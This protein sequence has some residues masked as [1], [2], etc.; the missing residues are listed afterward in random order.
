MITIK[1]IAKLAGTSRGTVDRVLN[2][3]GNVNPALERH[4]LQIAKE[5]NYHSN[6]FGKALVRGGQKYRIGVVINSVGNPFFDFV[7][8]GIM[9]TAAKYKDYGMEVHIQKIKGY[10]EQE[11]L[12][13][14][15]TLLADRPD[16]VAITPLD[17]P[18]VARRLSA[19]AP[20]PIVTLNNDIHIEKKLAFIGCDY[21]NSGSLSADIANM[22]LPEGG[23][24]SIITGSYKLLGHNERIQGFR[25]VLAERQSIHIVSVD[26]NN[27]DDDTSYRVTTEVLRAHQPRLIYFCAAGTEGGV[28]AVSDSSALVQ[29]VVVDDIGPMR[30]FLQQ[31]VIQ[32][33]VTQ[34]PYRQG[35]MMVETCFEYLIY[36]KSPEHVHNYMENQVKLRHSK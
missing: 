22:L 35:A 36:G 30:R 21:L 26:E 12:Q 15:D 4:I 10:D 17:T 23:E 16:A 27:D 18:A 34:Q 7:L 33:I 3:R 9:E 19:L 8:A 6:P 13:A 2:G 25:N 28:R 14:L 32:A 11:Q 5:H 20:L 24:V 29:V 1:E 31:G